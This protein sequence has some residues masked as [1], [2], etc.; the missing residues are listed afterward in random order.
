MTILIA[1]F[2]SV[3]DN[4][5][6]TYY[7]LGCQIFYFD[8]DRITLRQTINNIIRNNGGVNIELLPY[9]LYV[10]TPAYLESNTNL[11]VNRPELFQSLFDDYPDL[12][13]GNDIH[14]V[15]GNGY[16]YGLIRQLSTLILQSDESNESGEIAK[17]IAYLDF[18]SYRI[19]DNLDI[20]IRDEL[21]LLL[22]KYLPLVNNIDHDY[23]INHSIDILANM[24][25][26]EL[27]D[28]SSHY[29]SLFV[30]YSDSND[31]IVMC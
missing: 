11:D 15:S 20:T 28:F 6:N 16:C 18:A 10:G 9:Q 23:Y 27:K 13:F 5:A 14:S 3:S 17:L 12:S 1:P 4:I 2:N 22:E 25:F 31:I 26:S 8:P 7:N 29:R 21:E 24:N 30:N 19:W